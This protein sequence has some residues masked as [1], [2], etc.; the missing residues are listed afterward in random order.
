MS[1]EG[2]TYRQVSSKGLTGEN[3]PSVEGTWALWHLETH[4]PNFRSNFRIENTERMTGCSLYCLILCP[5][6]SCLGN[7]NILYFPWGK[8]KRKKH[9]R[10]HPEIVLGQHYLA[11]YILSKNVRTTIP[12]QIKTPSRR[13]A[14]AVQILKSHEYIPKRVWRGQ[15]AVTLL[16]LNT[17]PLTN[18]F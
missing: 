10:K 15:A 5:S 3:P 13:Q 8:K 1:G 7:H 9:L 11:V 2:E 4:L 17:L 6:G 18:Y 16:S 12:V 14:V